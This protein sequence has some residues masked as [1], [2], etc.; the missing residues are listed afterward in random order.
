MKKFNSKTFREKNYFILYDKDDY[1]ICYFD[2]FQELST[3]LNYPCYYLVYKF[4]QYGNLI[5]IVIG[6]KLYKLYT[7]C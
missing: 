6:N 1:I 2:N 3:R 4:N 5:P 7:S